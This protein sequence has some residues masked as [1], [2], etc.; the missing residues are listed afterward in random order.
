MIPTSVQIEEII[1]GK[2][3]TP[4]RW[5]IIRPGRV[6]RKYRNL[7]GSRSKIGSSQS[8]KKTV[9]FFLS[10]CTTQRYYPVQGPLSE[11]IKVCDFNI[12]QL[13]SGNIIYFD[14]LPKS[15]SFI[16]FPT[17]TGCC[18]C[19]ICKLLINYGVPS[20]DE[21]LLVWSIWLASLGVQ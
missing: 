12:V 4:I 11:I 1:M 9:P 19:L 8:F 16:S 13:R 20:V 2:I 10:Y 14:V 7:M 5:S 6:W 18:K 17:R 3:G 21:V 15:S